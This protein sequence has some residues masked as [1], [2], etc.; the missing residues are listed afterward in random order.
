[1]KNVCGL[2]CRKE[3]QPYADVVSIASH[4]IVIPR[5][6]NFAFEMTQKQ[7]KEKKQEIQLEKLINSAGEIINNVKRP[8][9]I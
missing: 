2:D 4:L 1:M 6:E 3:F 7:R 8:V 5:T 9:F